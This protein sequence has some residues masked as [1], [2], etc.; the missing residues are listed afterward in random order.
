MWKNSLQRF[1]KDLERT[2]GEPSIL[3]TL[4]I[5]GVCSANNLTAVKIGLN[6]VFAKDVE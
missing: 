3:D 4:T 5:T 6:A 2:T 1:T